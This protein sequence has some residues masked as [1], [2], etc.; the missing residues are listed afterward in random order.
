[1]HLTTHTRRWEDAAEVRT[2]TGWCC[3][4][5]HRFYGPD[6]SGEQSARYCCSTDAPCATEGCANRC[7]RYYTICEPCIVAGDTA[8]WNALPRVEW[9]GKAPICEWRGDEYFFDVES[10]AEHMAEHDLT[11]DTV[12]LVLCRPDNGQWFSMGEFLSD[13]IGDGEEC[14]PYCTDDIDETVND[15]ITSHA[16]YCWRPTDQAVSAQSIR[17]ALAGLEAS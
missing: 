14:L 12:R 16:P 9:D 17:D 2:V 7:R 6:A 4:T 5:C 1:M 11:A 13:S 15:W 10:L 8:R 3:V